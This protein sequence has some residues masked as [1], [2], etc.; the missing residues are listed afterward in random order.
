MRM[1]LR[2]VDANWCQL[3]QR[4]VII[5]PRSLRELINLPVL[6]RLEEVLE[7]SACVV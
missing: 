4:K 5:K 2:A 6:Q 1:W 3:H 7:V